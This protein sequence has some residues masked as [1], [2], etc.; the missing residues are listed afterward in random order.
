VGAG[1]VEGTIV[2][3]YPPGPFSRPQSSGEVTAAVAA[4]LEVSV[5]RTAPA[6][7]LRASRVERRTDL[8]FR[9]LDSRDNAPIRYERVNAETGEEVPWDQIVKAYEYDK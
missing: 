6:R 3:A 4:S 8:S 2:G 5:P 9:M 7:C 1:G